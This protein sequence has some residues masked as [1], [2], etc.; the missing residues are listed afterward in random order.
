MIN[1]DLN[2]GTE[3]FI[4]QIN[5]LLDENPRLSRAIRLVTWMAMTEGSDR[6]PSIAGHTPCVARMMQRMT[7]L[8]ILAFKNPTAIDCLLEA[9]GPAMRNMFPMIDWDIVESGD[10]GRI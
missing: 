8:V 1:E 9:T 3:P 4:D 6:C 2:L 5:E 10:E 7:T